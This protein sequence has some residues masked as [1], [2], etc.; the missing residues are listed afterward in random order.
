M[1]R[2]SVSVEA[3]SAGGHE[4]LGI[5][6][7][8]QLEQEHEYI[9]QKQ[10]IKIAYTSGILV[11]QMESWSDTLIIK[12]LSATPLQ[13]PLGYPRQGR[14]QSSSGNGI[15]GN[16]RSY[17]ALQGPVPRVP[18]LLALSWQQMF[19][20]KYSHEHA[21]EAHSG[22]APTTVPI[23]RTKKSSTSAKVS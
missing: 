14:D 18:N 1:K 4:N 15:V 2:G 7:D 3:G 21:M 9:R 23:P 5:E 12:V 10:V 17:D 19:L 6:P 8:T 20:Q 22:I 11:Q 16:L 13:H